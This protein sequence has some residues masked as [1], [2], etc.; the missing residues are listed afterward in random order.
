MT[1]QLTLPLP[2]PLKL[3]GGVDHL[4]TGIGQ[5]KKGPLLI[6]GEVIDK[7]AKGGNLWLFVGHGQGCGKPAVGV[8][9]TCIGGEG[10]AGGDVEGTAVDLSQPRWDALF[11][12]HPDGKTLLLSNGR[13]GLWRSVLE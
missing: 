3:R 10:V 9:L 4:A 12:L 6:V 7:P 11:A 8:I 1:L 2:Q 13:G 5:A